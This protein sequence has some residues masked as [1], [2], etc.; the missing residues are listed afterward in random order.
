MRKILPQR[1]ANETFTFRHGSFHYT[2]TA[3]YFEDQQVGEIFINSNKIGS[4]ADV[5]A[6]DAAIAVSLALQYGCPLEVLKKS[7]QRNAD[8]TP[9]GPL[10]HALEL[11][12]C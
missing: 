9:M 5:I 12:Q 4:E 10:S 6:S 11:I 1:R 2:V 8:G 3:G 7:M